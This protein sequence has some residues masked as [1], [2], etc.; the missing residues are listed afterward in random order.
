LKRAQNHPRRPE[1]IEKRSTIRTIV[2]TPWKNMT[3]DQCREQPE[4]KTGK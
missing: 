3:F 4:S 1:I 2:A